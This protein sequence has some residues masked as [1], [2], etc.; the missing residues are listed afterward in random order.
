MKIY[1]IVILVTVYL[2]TSTPAVASNYPSY[3]YIQVTGLSW[4]ILE[5]KNVSGPEAQIS[6]ELG[7]TLFVSAEAFQISKEETDGSNSVKNEFD[8]S[9]F[10]V[11]IRSSTVHKTSWYLAATYG[12]WIWDTTETLSGTTDVYTAKPNLTTLMI[13]FRSLISRQFEICGSIQRYELD[14]NNGD[15][16]SPSDKTS[17]NA[18]QLGLSYQFIEDLHLIL[19]YSKSET[20][21]EYTRTSLGLRYSF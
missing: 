15:E 18:I 20:D 1:P 12:K 9:S 8:V 21:V 6:L 16:F 4:D 14:E 10:G 13:G 19:D 17:G 7:D 5:L 11:G 2:F 3:S